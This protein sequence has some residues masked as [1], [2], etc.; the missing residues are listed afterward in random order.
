MK[1]YLPYIFFVTF[2]AI[3]VT[4]N[5]Y[6]TKRFNWYFSI[7]STRMLYAVFPPLSLLMFFGMMPLTNTTH[8]AGSFIY[9]LSAVIMGVLLYL[10]LSVLLVDLIGLFTSTSPRNYGFAAIALAVLISLGGIANAWN[11]KVTKEQVAIKGLQSEMKVMHLSDIHLGHFRGKNFLE[12]IVRLTNEQDVD[13]VFITGDLY[14][15]RINLHLDE[16]SPLKELRAPVYFVE[17]N[18]DNYSG[19][20]TIK[21][22]LGETG[23][24][25]LSNEV[26]HFGELQILGLNH[27]PADLSTYSMHATQKGSTIQSTLDSLPIFKEQPTVLLHHSPD[28]I[29]Y[30]NK[31]GVDLYLAGHTHAGQIFPIKYIANAMFEY[32]KGLHDYMGTQIFVSQGAGTFGPPMRVGTRSEITV[33]HLVPGNE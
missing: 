31:H 21:E 29:Q 12:R 5:I 28:G 6:L 8:S 3:L 33:L 27:M 1:Q 11:V 22:L 7:E 26:T 18:H 10:L 16:L 24:Q 25:V 15:G 19:V 20:K 30:A 23:V 2:I 4:A 17:G 14:D 9:M 32:N 13:V